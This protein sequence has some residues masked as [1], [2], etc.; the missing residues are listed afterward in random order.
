MPYPDEQET[1]VQEANEEAGDPSS[2]TLVDADHWNVLVRLVNAL[3]AYVGSADA[4]VG[5][6]SS[7]EGRL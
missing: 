2:G 7:H 4:T 5:D 3:Q 6:I 1:V